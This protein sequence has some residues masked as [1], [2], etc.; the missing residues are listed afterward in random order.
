MAIKRRQDGQQLPPGHGAGRQAAGWSSGA[1]ASSA[2]LF[3][4]LLFDAVQNNVIKQL[5]C[6]KLESTTSIPTKPLSEPTDSTISH[7]GFLHV[8]PVSLEV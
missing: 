5:L 2:I 8:S 7:V 6:L 4:F 3:V 1:P